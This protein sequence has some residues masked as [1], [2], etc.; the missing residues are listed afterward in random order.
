MLPLS[1]FAAAGLDIGDVVTG[2]GGRPVDG[3]PEMLFR[4]LSLGVGVETEIAYLADFDT[5]TTMVRLARAPESPARAPVVV[6]TRSI[7]NGLRVET[8]NPALITEL[9]LPFQAEGV[10]VTAVN[11]VSQR[12]QLRRG[13]ILRRINGVRLT[14]SDDIR[15][16]ARARAA[17][18]E[19]EF[20]RGGQR[21]VLRLRNR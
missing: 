2:I 11:G 10:V 5:H 9:G 18:L 15:R 3:G 20:E 21:G 14:R 13:D 17:V 4:L 1:P 19:V 8:L 12:T 7:L 16:V 6:E